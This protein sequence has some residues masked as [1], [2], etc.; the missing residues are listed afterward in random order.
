MDRVVEDGR[1]AVAYSPG[2][3]AGWYSWH[4][5]EELIFDPMLIELI[6]NN[7]L[8]EVET[9][10]AKKYGSGVYCGG[11]EQLKITWI[12]LGDRFRIEEYDGSES[13]VSESQYNWLN[14]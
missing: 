7:R 3:G 2:Y 14:A 12:P 13:V 10:V 11:A 4:G 8:D 1:V 6:R 5:I 9:Y